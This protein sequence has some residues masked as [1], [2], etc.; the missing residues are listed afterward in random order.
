MSACNTLSGLI[1]YR[2][3]EL[4]HPHFQIVWSFHLHWACLCRK[5]VLVQQVPLPKN[6]HELSAV[7]YV[8]RHLEAGNR[9][10][11]IRPL[12]F[13]QLPRC[14]VLARQVLELFFQ[15]VLP[16]LQ[17]DRLYPSQKPHPISRFQNRTFVDTGL[18]ARCPRSVEVF[19]RGHGL[20]MSR[21][22]H[23]QLPMSSVVP[24]IASG[25][26]DHTSNESE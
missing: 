9:S 3:Y 16:D 17:T 7:H 25:P 23:Y 26:I 10:V 15:S 12:P 18:A 6:L 13:Q 8:R 24:S 5:V 20:R 2:P 4:H 21:L 19:R 22:C 11:P 1:R 14:L